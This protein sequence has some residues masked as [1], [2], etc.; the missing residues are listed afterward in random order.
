[1]NFMRH[2]GLPAVVALV[3]GCGGGALRSPPPTDAAPKSTGAPDANEVSG[4]GPADI[5]T[6][7]TDSRPDNAPSD[8]A[9]DFSR[10]VAVS[11]LAPD[12]ALDFPPVADVVGLDGGAAPEVSGVQCGDAECGGDWYCF[13]WQGT[14]VP[15]RCVLPSACTSADV[16]A[17]FCNSPPSMCQVFGRSIY[18]EPFE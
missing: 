13:I 9:V 18:C 6:R 4:D 17:C 8:L 14:G 3:I 11:D 5:F 1:M 16:C 2:H 7:K 10:D 12:S 15:G